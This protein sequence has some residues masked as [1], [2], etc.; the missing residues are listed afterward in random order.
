[1]GSIID[2]SYPILYKCRICGHENDYL[3]RMITHVTKTHG[4]VL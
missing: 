3:D 2:M 4:A 1:M